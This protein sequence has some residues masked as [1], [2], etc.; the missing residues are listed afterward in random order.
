MAAKWDYTAKENLEAA[1]EAAHA[2]PTKTSA[3]PQ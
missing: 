2:K 3:A 1:P